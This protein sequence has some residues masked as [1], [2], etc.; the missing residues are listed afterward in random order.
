MMMKMR[1]ALAGIEL[2]RLIDNGL[3]GNLQ[4]TEGLLA[5]FF[6]TGEAGGGPV[7]H[8][9]ARGV[10]GAAPLGIGGGEEGKGGGLC[11]DGEVHGARV[12]RDKERKAAKQSGENGNGER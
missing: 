1:G 3:K 9:R 2:K 4:K 12:V 5:L 7:E 11:R 10:V 8:A 6:Q